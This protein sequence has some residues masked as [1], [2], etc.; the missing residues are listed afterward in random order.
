MRMIGPG[1]ASILPLTMVCIGLAAAAAIG[2]PPFGL[3]FSEMTVLNG[4]FASGQAAV[5]VLLLAALLP[6]VCGILYRLTRLLLRARDVVRRS[7]TAPV[8]GVPA[9]G[10]MLGLPL[11][12]TAWVPP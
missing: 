5:S 8:H 3:F 9:V 6:A 2:L 4:G 10:L 7:Q 1:I 12:F 11:P